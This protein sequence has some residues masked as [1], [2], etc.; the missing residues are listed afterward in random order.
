MLSR[1]PALHEKASDLRSEFVIAVNGTVKL[2]DG[3][4]INKNMPTGEIEVVPTELR[5]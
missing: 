2:R 1:T 5:C 3:N 4:T